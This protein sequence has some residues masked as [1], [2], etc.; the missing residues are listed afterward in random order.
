MP[1][2]AETRD[3]TLNLRTARARIKIS[4]TLLHYTARELYI[5][6]YTYGISSY[7]PFSVLSYPILIPFH[8]LVHEYS[9]VVAEEETKKT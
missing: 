5:Y 8:A 7:F 1:G 4:A 2:T 3:W 9:A 6:P